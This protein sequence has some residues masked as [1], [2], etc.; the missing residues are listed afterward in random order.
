[1]LINY[2]IHLQTKKTRGH[3]QRKKIR[4]I[5]FDLI[6]KINIMRISFLILILLASLKSN[7][8]I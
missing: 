6:F 4:K 5:K 1:M 2:K 3:K 8:T 7:L